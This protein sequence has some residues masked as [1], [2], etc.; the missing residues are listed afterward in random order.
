MVTARA[1]VKTW[2]LASMRPTA[3]I[4]V[5]SIMLLVGAGCSQYHVKSPSQEVKTFFVAGNEA[6][7]LGATC[8]SSGYMDLSAY[9]HL[10][11]VKYPPTAHV[12]V[13]RQPPTRPYR[14]F[15]VLESDSAAPSASEKVIAGLQEK[16]REIGADAILICQPGS[17]QGLAGL[18]LSSKLQ[19]VAIK[20]KLTGM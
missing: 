11:G 14:S 8:P 17:S 2:V 20:Y 10:A 15:A 1:A 16:A 3:L 4:P 9:S 5:L 19:A 18:A 6:N 7:Y 12:E 13:L